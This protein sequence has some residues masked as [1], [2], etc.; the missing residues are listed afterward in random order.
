MHNSAIVAWLVV[1]QLA[2]VVLIRCCLLLFVEELEAV[3]TASLAAG[4]T[5][6]VVTK[7]HALGGAGALELAEAVVT[8]CS[9][10]KPDFKY[11]YEVD[12]PIKVCRALLL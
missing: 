2:G 3:R 8:A 12:L 10:Q 5:A 9:G 1:L 6:A 11:L 4:A 7:H